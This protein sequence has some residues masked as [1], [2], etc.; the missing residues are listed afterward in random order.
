M[1]FILLGSGA[2]R[3]DLE[4]WGP[5]QVVQVNGRNLVFDC[6]RGASMRLVQAGIP[7][8]SITDMFFTHHH[9]DHNCDFPYLFLTSWVLGRRVPMKVTGPR[10]TRQFC[11][12]LFL[13]AYKEDIESRRGHP[14]YS[15]EG[16]HYDACD[17]LDE[18]RTLVYDGFVIKTTHPVHKQPV[19]DNL[20]YRIEAGD[21]SIVV[22]GDTT[23]CPGVKALAEGADLLVHECSFPSAMLQKEKWDAFHTDPR[24]LGFWAKAAGVKKLLVRHF[25]LR[26]GV[27]ELPDL[28]A[29]VRSTFGEDGLIVGEDLLTVEV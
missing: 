13:R 15:A 27:V 25:C 23:I 28:L 11:D 12:D 18:G 26:P 29:E 24:D 4:H 9:Y 20:A 2:V 5:S 6:G 19:I 10:G 3:P 8:Q 16:E 22:V 14:I 7:L 21:K 1:K 17:I